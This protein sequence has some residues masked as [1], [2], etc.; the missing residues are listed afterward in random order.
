MEVQFTTVESRLQ[1]N[2]TSARI[3]NNKWSQP[4]IIF[5]DSSETKIVLQKQDIFFSFKA[6]LIFVNNYFKIIFVGLN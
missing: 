6:A 4:G 5:I 3:P 2:P 1:G